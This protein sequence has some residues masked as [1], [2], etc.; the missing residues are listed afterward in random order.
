MM[1]CLYRK[2]YSWCKK[3]KSKGMNISAG[4]LCPILKKPWPLAS[5]LNQLADHGLKCAELLSRVRLFATAWTA[6]QA[7]LSMGF[8]RQDPELHATPPSSGS[9]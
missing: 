9:S 2:Q 8:S 7:P 6:R 4:L 5:M 3:H 1:C